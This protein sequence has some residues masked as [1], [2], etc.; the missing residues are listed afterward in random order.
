MGMSKS[1]PPE[2]PTV[3]GFLIGIVF[4]AVVVVLVASLIVLVISLRR[5]D[6]IWRRRGR[7]AAIALLLDLAFIAVAIYLISTSDDQGWTF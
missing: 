3:S 7:I 5:D 6:A 4:W 1:T 2:D